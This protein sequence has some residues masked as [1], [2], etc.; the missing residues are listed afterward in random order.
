[1]VSVNLLGLNFDDLNVPETVTRL[2]DRNPS[3]PFAYVVTPNADHLAR[4]RRSPAL[5]PIYEAA[6]LRL[7]DSHLLFNLARFCRVPAPQVATG[8]DVTAL[9]LSSLLSQDVAIIGFST[10]H[11]PA[12]QERCPNARFI[13]HTPPMNLLQDPIAFREAR[14]FAVRTNAQFT[15]I[16]LGS[17]LQELLAQAIATDPGARGTGLCIGAALE[18]CAGVKPRAPAWMQRAGLEWL[19]RLARNPGRLYGRYL[20]QDPPVLFSL[21]RAAFK[22]YWSG[23]LA[24]NQLNQETNRELK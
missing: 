6:W 17:P 4:L 3:A 16:G 11:L 2:L 20:I 10:E 19:H 14:D 24:R 12:L 9:L 21:L 18:F 1:M 15:L 23:M 13:L 7:L 22:S 8:T 5:V